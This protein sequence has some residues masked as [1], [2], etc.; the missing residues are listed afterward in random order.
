M[1]RPA[2]LIAFGL[3]ALSLVG[4]SQAAEQD[5][6]RDETTGEITENEDIGVFRLREGDC[7]LMP[8]GGIANQE[9][10]AM[11]AIPCDEPHEAEVLALVAVPGDDDAPFPGQ[12]ALTEQAVTDCVDQFEQSTGRDFMTDPDWDLTYLSPTADSWAYAN[13]REIVCL[14]TPL[15]G[16]PTTE[17]AAG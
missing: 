1:P 8:T 11:E 5:A 15:D 16:E 6:T 2:L 12:E 13:D 3:T 17:L 9:V 4:C 10:E 14:V 7:L